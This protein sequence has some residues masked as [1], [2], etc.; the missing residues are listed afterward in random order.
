M[1]NIGERAS[2]KILRE[3][4][5]GLYLDGGQ[6]GEVLLPHREVPKDN[7]LG[8]FLDV[9]LY[10]DSEDRPVATLLT[11]KAMPGDFAKLK[12]VD[13]TGVGAFLDWGLAKELLVPFREQT[14]R[15]EPGKNYL[16]HVHVD[17]V[18]GRIIASARLPRHLD[19]TPHTFRAG[20][21]VDLIIFGKTDLGY[22]AIING[23]HSG[24]LFSEGVFQPLQPGEKTRGYISGIREDGKIDLTLHAPGRA[25]VT[26]LEERILA[27]LGARGGFWSIG[28]HS[29]AAEIHEELG[30]SKRTFKQTIG[31]LLKKRLLQI[32]DRGI[33]LAK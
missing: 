23:S 20:D 2:L 14:T 12:C 8:G 22:K 15:M 31:A 3:K 25:R 6:L 26:D 29:S 18:S 1:A 28:D 9:F 4:S 16:V 13:V 10:T 24:L 11:P 17:P 33:R 27:E 5:F 32:E 19:L 30:V 7:V 21:E